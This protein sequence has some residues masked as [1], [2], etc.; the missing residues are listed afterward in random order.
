VASVPAPPDP[1]NTETDKVVSS[2]VERLVGSAASAKGIV[3]VDGD[4]TYVRAFGDRQHEPPKRFTESTRFE[5]GSVSKVFA[6]LL[7]ADAVGR[8]E[9]G[10]AD[11]LSRN[12]PDVHVNQYHGTPITLIDVASQGV[13]F[14]MMPDNWKYRGHDLI[15]PEYTMDLFRDYLGRFEHPF[16]P[17]TGYSYSNVNTTLVAMAVS[18]RAGKSYESLLRERIFYPLAM[19]DSGFASTVPET[20]DVL[21]GW[22]EGKPFLPRVDSSPLA[23]CCSVRTTLADVVKFLRAGAH[24][25]DTLRSAFNDLAEPRRRIDEDGGTWAT[26]G[27]IAH[28][29]TRVLWKNGVTRGQR[30]AMAVLPSRRQ[31]L[32]VIVN[33]ESV[34]VD[35]VGSALA[36]SLFH[37]EPDIEPADHDRFVVESVPGDATAIDASFADAM[38]AVAWQAPSHLHAGET[39]R[40]RVYFRSLAVADRD[41]EL[42]VHV[43]RR[44]AKQSRIRADHFPGGS[45]DSTV[46]WKPG[47]IIVD[48]FD[49][50]VPEDTEPGPY[51]VWFGFYYWYTR[52]TASSATTRVD[53]NRVL[54]PSIV[55]DAAP[56][57]KTK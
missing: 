33:D 47:E 19:R 37:P 28:P 53:S 13:G 15:E 5:I 10:F 20:E 45:A 11:L 17:G 8:G 21:E 18:R 4:H 12:L 32:F 36:V 25:S 54:G 27:W 31:G 48:E 41:W 56:K 35:K 49:V 44:G 26:L 40:V 22:G 24:V 43:D 7:F 6:G 30:C 16:R 3:I 51:E 38:K 55:I 34:D 29:R 23:P 39:G 1:W 2:T 57:K 46:R 52:A 42:F 50:R 14:P 9:V